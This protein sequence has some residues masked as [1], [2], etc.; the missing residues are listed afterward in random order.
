MPA[1]T[2]E[3]IKARAAALCASVRAQ[4]VWCLAFTPPHTYVW[5][6][7]ID[8]GEAISAL[9]AALEAA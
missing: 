3:Q 2:N 6:A 9:E 4:L 1:A 5:N 7:L 8:V